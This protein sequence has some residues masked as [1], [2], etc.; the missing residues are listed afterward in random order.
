MGYLLAGLFGW[1]LCVGY[2]R[3]FLRDE[4]KRGNIVI[5]NRNK[6]IHILLSWW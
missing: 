2:I 6:Y 4:I 3:W 1:T 5:K